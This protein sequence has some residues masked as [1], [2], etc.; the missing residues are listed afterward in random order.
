V[1][2][3]QTRILVSRA[4]AAGTADLIALAQPILSSLTAATHETSA[5]NVRKGDEAEVIATK[6]SPQRLISMM[7]LGDRSPLYATSSGKVILASL[8]EDRLDAYLARVRLQSIAAQTLT[9]R[10]ALRKEIEVVRSA[11]F[12]RAVEEFTPGVVGLAVPD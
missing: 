10:S 2:F 8:A 4:K 9:S 7:R 6:L 11:G 5:L 1:C 3:A 12:G